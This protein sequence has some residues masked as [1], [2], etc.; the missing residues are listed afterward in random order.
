MEFSKLLGNKFVRITLM[1]FFFL[2]IYKIL[3][4][5]GI[6]FAIDPNILSMY[7]CW[8][9]MLVLFG[10]LL[11]TSNTNFNVKPKIKPIADAI[12]SMVDK[13]K[14]VIGQGTGQPEAPAPGLATGLTTGLAGVAVVPGPAA[15][16]TVVP[17]P[18][19]GPVANKSDIVHV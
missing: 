4:A 16:V 10:A 17:G 9:G 11:Q 7:L 14:D 12:T 18:A 5:I 1:I 2:F 13:L 6:F 19:S 15:P 8:I 3:Y